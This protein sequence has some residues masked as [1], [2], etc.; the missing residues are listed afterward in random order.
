MN[1]WPATLPQRSQRAGYSR[2]LGDARLKTP[3]DAGPGKTSRRLSFVPDPVKAAVVMTTAQRDQFETFIQ[4]TLKGG[5]LPFQFPAVDQGGT[6]IVKLG[7]TM[8]NWTEHSPGSWLVVL[9]LVKLGKI[10]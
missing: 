2:A 9:D 3:M 1:V 5:T 10:A 4:T 7:D 8:P 6:W